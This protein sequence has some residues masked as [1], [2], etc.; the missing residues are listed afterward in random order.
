MEKLIYDFIFPKR[1]IDFV[2]G[3]RE[4]NGVENSLDREGDCVN[5]HI[6]KHSFFNE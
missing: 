1:S 2:M 5:V 6:L 3:Y 4:I